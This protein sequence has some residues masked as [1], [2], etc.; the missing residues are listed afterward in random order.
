MGQSTTTRIDV[1][2]VA[3]AIRAHD[4][5]LVVTH[6]NPD[7]DA[8]GSLL[9]DDARAPRAR[10]GRRHVPVGRTRRRRPSTDFLDLATFARELPAD[11][12]ERVLLPSTA[13][14]SSASAPTGRSSSAR[15][16]S[17]TSTTTTTTRASATSTWSSPTPPRLPRSSRDVLSLL[18][19]P[20]TPEIAE[21]L[22]VALV[23]DTGRFQYTNTTPEGAAARRRAG[24]GGRRRPRDLPARLRDRPVREAE[25]ARAGAR[26]RRA[27]RG[28]ARSSSATC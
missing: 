6:E 13:R 8:L 11:L 16:S 14:T 2:A 17:S 26:A 9:G 19:V 10:Q 3:D 25:A 24:R 1:Q 20:L 23:T 5:F 4:A 21:A 27:L 7:G 28:R 22:Y 18:D 12:E 15:S